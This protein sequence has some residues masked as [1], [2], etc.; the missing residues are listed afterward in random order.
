MRRRF[1]PGP[2][3]AVPALILGFAGLAGCSVPG[4]GMASVSEWEEPAWMAQVRQQDEAFQSAMI[5]CFAEYGLEATRQ[6]GGG[7]VG[8]HFTT[9]DGS[10]PEI[11]PGVQAI[12]DEAAED[13]NARVP[14]PD[15][16][17]SKTLD[18]AAYERMIDLRDC[19][20]AHGY[21]VP[22]PPSAEVWIDSGLEAAFNPYVAILL[23]PSPIRIPEDELRSLM[24]AC[25]QSGP[26]Y[27]STGPTDGDG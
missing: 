18:D 14:L 1:V 8:I 3:S 21:D 25:P 26:N 23:G 17:T 10:I 13:C 24:E 15:H 16:H 22:E 11:P 12:I 4:D 2:S 5:A 20:I 9:D 7:D 27:F 6:I 19:I